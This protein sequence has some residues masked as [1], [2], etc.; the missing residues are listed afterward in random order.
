MLTKLLNDR[1]VRKGLVDF[2][3]AAIGLAVAGITLLVGDLN[4][5]QMGIVVAVVTPVAATAR[6]LLRKWGPIGT[7]PDA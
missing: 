3:L 6:R 5:E 1:T 2:G 7:D 4:P